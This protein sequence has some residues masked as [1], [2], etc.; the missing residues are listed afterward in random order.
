MKVTMGEG[1][2]R[3]EGVAGWVGM[4]SKG[5]VRLIGKGDLKEERMG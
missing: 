5:T 1:E 4:G 2:G 3:T